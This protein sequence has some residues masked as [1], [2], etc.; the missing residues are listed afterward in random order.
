[1]ALF[2]R[3]ETWHSSRLV[4]P[5][6]GPLPMT[7]G[8]ILAA[9]VFALIAVFANVKVRYDQG[10]IWKSNPEITEIAGAMA[11]S[12]ADAPISWGMLPLPRQV[13]RQMITFASETIRMAR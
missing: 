6:L 3:V 11:F 10:Q 1:M 2:G 7:S 12:T 9:V 5:W 13:F 4:R 8:L